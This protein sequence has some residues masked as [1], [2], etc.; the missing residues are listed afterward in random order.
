MERHGSRV[1]PEGSEDE[2]VLRH[3]SQEVHASRRWS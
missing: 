3:D 1:V 2:V